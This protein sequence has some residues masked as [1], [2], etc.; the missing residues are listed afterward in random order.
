MTVSSTTRK[1]GPFAGNGIVTAF[2]FAF[3]IFTKSDIKLILVSPTGAS[4][5][6]TL[7]SDYSVVLNVNQT[8]TPGGTIT[9]PITGVTLQTGYALVVLG[10]L[11]LDQETN[12]TNGGGFYPQTI[13]DMVDRATIQIQQVAEIAGRAIVVTEAENTAPVLPPAAARAGTILG[14][15][16]SGNV[17]TLP[18]TSSIGAG[19]MHV[20]LFEVG[21]DFAANGSTSVL[22]LSRA[23]GSLTNMWVFFDGTYQSR[24]QV[25][26]LN[27][28]VL[29]FKSG[30]PAG[31]QEVAVHIGTVLSLN[32]PA[33]G[34][35]GPAQMNPQFGPTSARPTPTYPGQHWLDTTLGYGV[36]ANAALN[37]WLNA[38]GQAP[39]GS[40]FD[41]QD[42]IVHGKL[43]LSAPPILPYAVFNL[44][45]YGGVGDGVTANDAALTALLAAAALTSATRIAIKIGPGKWKFTAGATLT[46]ANTV[47][48]SISIVG[49]GQDITELYWP[50]GAGG[51]IINCPTPYQSFHIRDLS[52]TTGNIGLSQALSI[53][54]N[55]TLVSGPANTAMSDV[56]RVTFRGSDGYAVNSG[57]LWSFAIHTTRLSNLNVDSCLFTGAAP[58][59]GGYS[60]AG[61]GVEIDGAATANSCVFNFINCTFNYLGTGITAQ[62]GVQGVTLNSC[63]FTGCNYGFT[64]PVGTAGGDQLCVWGCQFN[65]GTYDI[66]TG[67]HFD[68]TLISGC[69]F[70]ADSAGKTC[71]FLQSYNSFSLVGNAFDGTYMSNQI[72][73]VCQNPDGGIGG[74]ISGNVFT[75]LTIAIQLTAA[76]VRVNIQ[77]NQYT[78][79]T[80]NVLNQ[81]TGTGTLANTLG[82]G[83]L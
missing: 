5:T 57:N 12:I 34:S 1:A 58:T 32:V 21:T 78:T 61:T 46:V 49:E 39:T 25:Q 18:I 55:S 30:I 47:G 51:L 65:C 69:L 26:T 23:P 56:T 62:G 70:I 31:T 11:P 19:D 43:T 2:P 77:S 80:T 45:S 71:V 33:N 7:D 67:T 38:A 50:N 48:A 64:T 10:D 81:G 6:L 63:N 8:S 83:S 14:F 40:A 20:D 66:V 52:M 35:V 53:F 28:T 9:Y 13:E 72:G 41:L 76:S 29:T 74:V 37:G 60:T 79:N 22:N 82:G 3:K 17:T 54:Q 24:S 68:N 4:T 15:D 73:V 59:S 75:G 42:A 27:G 16:S 44:T 36:E